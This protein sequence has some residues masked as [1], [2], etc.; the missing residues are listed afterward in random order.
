MSAKNRPCHS[1]SKGGQV[2]LSFFDD[3]AFLSA[4]PTEPKADDGPPPIAPES[5]ELAPAQALASVAEPTPDPEPDIDASLEVDAEDD[6]PPGSETDGRPLDVMEPLP[7]TLAE[8][9]G[10]LRNAPDAKTRKVVDMRSALNAIGRVLGKRLNQIP[11]DPT[12]L[13]VLVANVVPSPT[14]VSREHWST[15]QSRLRAAL[16]RA[17]FDVMPGRDTTPLTPAWRT[18]VDT[19]PDMRARHGLSRLISYLSRKGVTPG[20]VQ[21]EHLI[22]FEADLKNRSLKANPDYLYN[23]TSRIWNDVAAKVSGWPQ[24][25]APVTP[26]PRKYALAWDAFPPSFKADA[27][28]FLSNSGDPDVF[29]EH[30]APG[31][32]SSTNDCRRKHILEL[33]SALVLSGKRPEAIEKLA[34]LVK[35]EN[36]TV[37][38]RWH[39]ERN[40]NKTSSHISA[41]S[42]LLLTLA[43]HWVRDRDAVDHLERINDRL[44]YG[45]KGMAD[46]NRVLLRQFDHPDNRA[47]LLNLPSTVLGEA[48]QTRERTEKVARRV[49]MALAVEIL[50]MAPMRVNNLTQ[51]EIGRHLV[52][53]RRGNQRQFHII[54]TP[55]ETKTREPFEMALPDASVRILERYLDFYRPLLPG[56]EGGHLFPVEGGGR[57]S[58]IAFSTSISNFI[59]RETGLIVHAHLFRHLAG[60]LYL[61]AV[62][63]DIETVRR[64]LGHRSTTTTLNNYAELRSD[65]AFKRYD[66]V[67]AQQRTQAQ[68]PV[69][70]RRR[71]GSGA[72]SRGGR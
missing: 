52:E 23:A 61:D 37:A 72:K 35:P 47:A 10:W 1:V 50:I 54:L 43:R 8:L 57:R 30:Y 7:V 32:R 18:M 4:A 14:E 40:D 45:K 16:L 62:P 55:E 15:V 58:T 48:D 69:Q 70:K 49:M 46:K 53:F 26:D 41:M 12:A 5:D 2:Q 19:L 63:H 67:V 31:V 71:R 59:K 65:H 42:Y 36:A 33:A 17:G 44:K 64:V 24:V 39:H 22:A 3:P 25:E 13:G 29:S 20:D 66:D 27:D 21:V 38:L 9:E 60:K 51:I 28:A 11:A 68:A 56:A 34:D 6:S